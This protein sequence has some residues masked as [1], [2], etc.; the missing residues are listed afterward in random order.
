[1]QESVLAACSEC[2]LAEWQASMK[3]MKLRFC[4]MIP[5]WVRAGVVG[6]IT[7]GYPD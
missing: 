5:T 6:G 2:S 3:R 1:M 4:V 7:A